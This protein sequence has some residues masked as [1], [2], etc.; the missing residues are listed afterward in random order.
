MRL[1]WIQEQ[2]IWIL[3]YGLSEG[4]LYKLHHCRTKPLSDERLIGSN[5]SGKC[6][7]E[8]C[9]R[10]DDVIYLHSYLLYKSLQVGIHFH[11]CREKIFSPSYNCPNHFHLWLVK[12]TS[13]H[14]FLGLQGMINLCTQWYKSERLKNHKK[15]NARRS[16][17]SRALPFL[18]GIG[19]C[20]SDS[21]RGF[22]FPLYPEM[23]W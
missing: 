12:W 15:S 5:C 8:S 19:N 2:H 20:E 21:I 14:F 13:G 7:P 3:P 23:H 17:G 6:V 16:K 1:N 11:P 4:T 10:E 18:G 9:N 22:I